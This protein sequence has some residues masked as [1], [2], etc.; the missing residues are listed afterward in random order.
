MAM[1][2][3]YLNRSC[4]ETCKSVDNELRD[5]TIT[6]LDADTGDPLTA[7]LQLYKDG[8]TTPDTRGGF[9]GDTTYDNLKKGTYS[10]TAS[11]PD[12]YRDE[13]ITVRVDPADKKDYDVIVRMTKVAKVEKPGNYDAYDQACKKKRFC[14]NKTL[15]EGVTY[16]PQAGDCQYVETKCAK[17]CDPSGDRCQGSQLRILE[18][19]FNEPQE[20]L[21]LNGAS[22]ISLG[23]QAVVENPLSEKLAGFSF[24]V[25]AK[26]ANRTRPATFGIRVFSGTLKQDGSFEITIQSESPVAPSLPVKNIF[27]T[28]WAKDVSGASVSVPLV[29]PAPEIISINPV[30]KPEAWQGAY[31]AYTVEAKDPD[32][33]MDFFTVIP[34]GGTVRYEGLDWDGYSQKNM[35]IFSKVDNITSKFGWLVPETTE[36]LESKL[37]RK[38]YKEWAE[39]GKDVLVKTADDYLSDGIAAKYGEKAAE[40][41]PSFAMMENHKKYTAKKTKSQSPVYHYVD[42]YE[43]VKYAAKFNVKTQGLGKITGALE[44][45]YKKFSSVHDH[46][47][48]QAEKMGRADLVDN[49][50]ADYEKAF[51]LGSILLDGAR[52]IDGTI[53]FALDLGDALGIEGEK[54][55]PIQYKL[56]MH[57]KKAA[58][59]ATVGTLQHVFESTADTFQAGR[60]EITS[61]YMQIIVA[62]TD[63]DGYRDMKGILVDVQGYEA[64]IRF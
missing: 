23:G 1:M 8:E 45:G 61:N 18:I 6:A 14:R 19:K 43:L 53:D 16:N 57:A 25:E 10:I 47:K 3:R 36:Y 41:L 11:L 27:L 60:A 30:G 46:T 50:F 28:I 9:S 49:E 38:I 54:N 4:E 39:A 15:Y 35:Y 40:K 13:T 12:L 2:A 64:L 32:K 34:E 24:A 63:K 37:A 29:S 17:G 52:L 51:R 26:V 55:V 58:L 22:S 33:N 31:K 20:A 7:I 56:L 5:I 48:A 44:S 59:M 42:E 21:L 62:I